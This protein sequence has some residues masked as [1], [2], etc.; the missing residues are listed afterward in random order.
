MP[1]DRI[2]TSPLI[3]KKLL[4]ICMHYKHLN[5]ASVLRKKNKIKQIVIKQFEEKKNLCDI[6]KRNGRETIIG[7][8]IIK[9]YDVRIFV[10]NEDENI[11]KTQLLLF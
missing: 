2:T 5:L 11:C 6:S 3:F 10:L 8:I 1:I 9:V 7:I 4:Y